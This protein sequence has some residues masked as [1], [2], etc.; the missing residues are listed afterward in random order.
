LW[1]HISFFVVSL[2]FFQRIPD[3]FVQEHLTDNYPSSQ[4]A[5]IFSPLGKFWRVELG[6]HQSGMLLGDG[7]E[8]FLT[9]HDLSEGNILV[10]RYEDD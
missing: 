2:T 3:K 8:Q 4:K 5:M 1:L 9:A 7:W 10:F 6:R